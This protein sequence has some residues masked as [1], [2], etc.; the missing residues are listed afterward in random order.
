MTQRP[1]LEGWRRTRVLLPQVDQY[2]W[3]DDQAPLTV[4]SVTD[5]AGRRGRPLLADRQPETTASPR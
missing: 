4:R 1:L 3:I 5:V 2:G